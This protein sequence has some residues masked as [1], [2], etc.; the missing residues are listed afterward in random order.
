MESLALNRLRGRGGG[1]TFKCLSRGV[2]EDRTGPPLSP[3]ASDLR[4]RRAP[5]LGV[6]YQTLSPTSRWPPASVPPPACPPARLGWHSEP[7]A[8]GCFVVVA[9]T[10]SRTWTPLEQVCVTLL[11]TTPG[12]SPRCPCRQ[13]VTAGPR[14]VPPAPRRGGCL[15]PLQLGSQRPLR[16]RCRV[17]PPICSTPCTPSSPR[18][19]ALRC[20]QG[21]FCPRPLS[22]LLSSPYPSVLP[23]RFPK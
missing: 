17:F 12:P 22:L 3:G 19:F 7:S 5:R 9:H 4:S 21:L 13:L 23:W 11:T 2:H 16:S 14:V 20:R 18:N 8:G 15:L 1:V 6:G 10:V